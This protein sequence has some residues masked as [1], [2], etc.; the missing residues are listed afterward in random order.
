MD[1]EDCILLGVVDMTPVDDISNPVVEI[2]RIVDLK[3]V[4]FSELNCVDL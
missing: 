3:V 4:L 2:G 1:A